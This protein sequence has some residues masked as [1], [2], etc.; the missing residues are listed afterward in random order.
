MD[1]VR[2]VRLGM[3]TVAIIALCG[4]VTSAQTAPSPIEGT[5]P[6]HG[7]QPGDSL[8]SLSARSGVDWITLASENGLHSGAALAPG[9]TL[10]IDGRHIALDS[11]ADGILINVPQRMLFVIDRAAVVAGFPIAVGRADWRTHWGRSRSRGRQSIPPGTFRSR[12]S[13]RWRTAAAG[14]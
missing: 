12:F 2:D 3:R 9:Q 6:S 4:V 5:V 14:C 7:V 13:G 11:A 10:T 1:T 8:V